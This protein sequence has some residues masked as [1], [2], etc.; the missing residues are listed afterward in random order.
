[1]EVVPDEEMPLIVIA[2][3]A[4]KQLFAYYDECM[5]PEL[6]TELEKQIQ[7][8]VFPAID[9]ILDFLKTQNI[10]F[11]IG[12]YK[13]YIFPAHAANAI[14]DVKCRSK[15]DSLV[16]TFGFGD[17]AEQV[18]AIERDG[19]I[20]S[21]CVSTRENGHCGEAWVYTDPAYRRLGLAQQVVGMWAQQIT[22]LGKVP[23]Y[24]H[25][26]DNIPSATLAKRLELQPVFEE[27]VITQPN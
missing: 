12:H 23:F 7:D 15:Q 2:Q 14:N 19:R 22:E 24:S 5:Q 26:I 13:T 11:D 21:A 20:V 10:P 17:F 18:Y 4:D 27:I 6:Q 1:V 3:L 8:I 16:Q 9:S 25:K